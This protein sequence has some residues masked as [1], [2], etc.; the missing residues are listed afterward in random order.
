[1]VA[2]R[3]DDQA[4]VEDLSQE[5]VAR[6]LRASPRLSEEALLGY[7]IVTAQNLVISQRRREA[8]RS[9][10]T[11]RT[12]DLTKPEDPEEVVLR[13]EIEA[14]LIQALDR[15]PAEEREL[16]VDHEIHG[17]DTA[18]LAES[19]GSSPGGVATRLARIRAKLRVEFVLAYR[20]VVPAS[21]KCRP[22]LISLSAGDIRRQRR[23]KAG[24][25][26]VGCPTCRSV[27]EPLLKRR[28]SLAGFLPFPVLAGKLAAWI[29]ASPIK[30]ALTGAVLIGGAS[31]ATHAV[32]DSPPAH[33]HRAVSTAPQS[34]I[35]LLSGKPLVVTAQGND[36]AA[37]VGDRIRVRSA[38]VLGVPRDE[39]FWISSGGR[40][41]TPLWVHLKV[42]GESRK[43]VDAND[44]VSFVGLI[45]HGSPT[46]GPG[47]S[48]RAADRAHL[49]TTRIALDN[50]H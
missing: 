27:S 29:K 34:N 19:T 16:I 40:T 47:R 15:L 35:V 9:L 43:D 28:A 45:A 17:I 26:L 39:G 2:A 32:I 13:K 10:V 33:H 42:G 36:L 50:K 46:I 49:R 6:I 23:L 3:V 21:D 48:G 8:R 4:T 31:V 1:M 25:H 20:N 5:T 14:A 38:R 37:H 7:A 12:I 44:K 30:A 41:D 22:V 18:T 24:E 11:P